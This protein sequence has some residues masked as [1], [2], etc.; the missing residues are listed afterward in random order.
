AGD[1]PFVRRELAAHRDAQSEARR[2]SR[3]LATHDRRVDA[4]QRRR[5][6]DELRHDGD[7]VGAGKIDPRR[8]S[9]CVAPAKTSSDWLEIALREAA[10]THAKREPLRARKRSTRETASKT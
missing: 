9:A 7:R 1:C 8:T 6:R 10:P 4:A 3:N 2:G 5:D